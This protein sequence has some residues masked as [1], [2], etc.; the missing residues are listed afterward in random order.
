MTDLPD[1]RSNWSA[2]RHFIPIIGTA[3]VGVAVAVAAWFAVSA[4]EARLARVTF[5]NIAG[6]YASVLQNGVDQY[7][8]KLVAARA[9]YDASVKVDADEFELFTNRLLHGQTAMMRITWSPRVTHDERAAFETRARTGGIAG[10]TI[11]TW[12][13]E[14]TLPTAPPE[15][16]YFPVLYSTGLSKRSSVLGVDL[17]SEPMQG[18]AIERARDGDQMATAPDVVIRFGGA[19]Q[20][21]GIFVALPVYRRG[22][23][24]TSVEDRRRNT[25][26]VLGGTFRTAAVVDA[27]LATKTLPQDV[28]LFLYPIDAGPESV[29]VYTHAATHQSGVL[30]AKSF[31]DIDPAPH[32]STIL[33]AGDASWNL[34]V[35]PAE[36]RL[37]SYYRAW[38]V[39]VFVVLAFGAVLAQMWA[40][41]RNAMRLE[42]V[43]RKVLELAS[44]DL[45][46]SLANR[47]AFL[48]RL[49][50][51]LPPAARPRR[52]SPCFISTSTIS[53]T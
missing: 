11:K 15:A 49:T 22:M 20:Q 40:S 10:Y 41:V 6:D 5:N 17:N 27:I 39:L 37:T 8:G 2:G 24:Q 19:G 1:I 7:L 26:G 28:D 9:F 29:P 44:T 52:P 43:N 30:K 12:V 14:G 13:A 36:G 4:W 53:R 23:P 46:T 51:A 48:G 42:A 25:L 31:A 33:K 38:I 21:Q 47:R 50:I 3:C 45:L 35:T 34:V 32:W 18:Q 16:E